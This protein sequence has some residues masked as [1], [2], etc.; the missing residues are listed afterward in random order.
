MAL[1]AMETRTKLTAAGEERGT[2]GGGRLADPREAAAGE[3]VRGLP[4]HGNH[5]RERN[6]AVP[7]F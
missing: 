6:L 3:A 2:G 7:H 1:V 4:R 5:P